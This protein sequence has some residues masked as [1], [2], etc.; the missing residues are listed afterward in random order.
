MPKHT[1]IIAAF[2][3][4]KAITFAAFA[5]AHRAYGM[6]TGHPFWRLGLCGCSPRPT[7][8]KAESRITTY[9]DR[10]AILFNRCSD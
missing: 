8:A 2:A 4:A 5:G 3:G 1:G 10:S 7:S 9:G 6:P